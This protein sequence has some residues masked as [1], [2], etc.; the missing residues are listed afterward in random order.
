LNPQLPSQLTING[1]PPDMSEVVFSIWYNQIRPIA[2]GAMIVGAAKTMWG[3]RGSLVEAFQRAM[4][5]GS[6][7]VSPSRLEQDLDP[8]VILIATVLLV[9]PMSLLYYYSAKVSPARLSLPSLC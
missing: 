2:V 8:K 7:V 4:R 5:K 3:L 6:R 1:Q 9:I